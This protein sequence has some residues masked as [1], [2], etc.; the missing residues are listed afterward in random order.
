MRICRNFPT[1]ALSYRWRNRERQCQNSCLCVARGD[2]LR[3]LRDVFA[4]DKLG[5]DLLVDSCAAQRRYGS[6]PIRCVLGISDGDF[7]DCRIKERLPTKL[8]QI[9][10]RIGGH[11]DYDPSQRIFI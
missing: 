11:P 8:W 3:R 6:A 10:A 7:L 4:V 2:E 5:A 9:N 1:L